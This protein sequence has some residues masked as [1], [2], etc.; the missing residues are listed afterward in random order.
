MEMK[1][2]KP[3]KPEGNKK[4][5]GV[6]RKKQPFAYA[7]RGADGKWYH[8]RNLAKVGLWAGAAFILPG[9][10]RSLADRF[11]NWGQV[12]DGFDFK[13]IFDFGDWIKK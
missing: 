8:W 11:I 12:L 1:G 9:L 10:I 13:E 6:A 3:P 5:V 7:R 2:K 4:A